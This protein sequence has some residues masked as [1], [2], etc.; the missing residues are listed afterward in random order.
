MPSRGVDDLAYTDNGTTP[1]VFQIY[2]SANT[3][4][5]WLVWQLRDIDSRKRHTV[6][7]S[8]EESTDGFQP[9]PHERKYVQQ[10]LYYKFQH[11]IV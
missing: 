7:G 6:H 2:Y 1:S 5:R 3:D 9:A 4:D 8:F 10:Q 11:V